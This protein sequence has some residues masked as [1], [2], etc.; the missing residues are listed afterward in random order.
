MLHEISPHCTLWNRECRECRTEALA[1]VEPVDDSPLL[2]RT[3]R[4]GGGRG[5]RRRLLDHLRRLNL[6]LWL[7]HLSRKLMCGGG[8]QSLVTVVAFSLHIRLVAELRNF[9]SVSNANLARPHSPQCAAFRP[10]A[11]AE[12]PIYQPNCDPKNPTNPDSRGD[13]C[14]PPK[15]G[16]ALPSRSRE[17]L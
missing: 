16:G 12:L 11:T 8:P 15:L 3:I 5:R 6:L 14:Q 10:H 17:G 4:E 1:H 9:R 7:G 2:A 13:P